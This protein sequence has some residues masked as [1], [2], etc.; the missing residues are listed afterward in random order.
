MDDRQWLTFMGWPNQCGRSAGVQSRGQDFVSAEP[1]P[2]I[3]K[4]YK[5]AKPLSTSLCCVRV[6]RNADCRLSLKKKK[7]P[8]F[9]NHLG[10]QIPETWE[11]ELL[12]DLKVS[13]SCFCGKCWPVRKKKKNLTAFTHS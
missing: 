2:W 9:M 12:K 5:R 8:N 4:L 1:W 10:N 13:L 3:S 11:A 6:P 7:K